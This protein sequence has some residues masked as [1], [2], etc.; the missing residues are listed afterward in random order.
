MEIVITTRDILV[1]VGGATAGY[2][3]LLGF[4]AACQGFMD[5]WRGLRRRRPAEIY[6]QPPQRQQQPNNQ[7]NQQQRNQQPKGG[8]QQQQPRQQ[9]NVGGYDEHPNYVN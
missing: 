6:Q 5:F 9:Q 2:L 1:A 4:G 8:I 7:N 3:F